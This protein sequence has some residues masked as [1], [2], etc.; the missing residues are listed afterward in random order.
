ME[1]FLV[2]G[3]VRDTLLGEP[4]KERDW[5]VVGT[6]TEELIRQGFQ[7]VGQH[8]PVFL[9]PQT[10]EEYALPRKA[11][12]GVS[13]AP[14]TVEDDLRRRDL[15]INA[16]A[17]DQHGHLIDPLNGLRDLK[18]KILR[19][20]PAFRDDPVRVL[21]LARFAARYHHLGFRI[22]PET[23]KLARKMSRTGDLSNLV[24]ER[25]FA[26][27]AK[28]MNESSPVVFIQTLQ[29]LGAL[30]E[31]IP[32]VDCLFGVP[33]PARFHPEVDTGLHTLMVLEQAC[34]LSPLPEVRF[35]ALVHDVGKGTTP[36]EDW[37]R[38]IGHESRGVPLIRLLAARLCL[39]NAWR[40]L[41]I[42]VSRYH[43]NCHRALELR[44]TTLLKTLSGLDAFR[45]P[46]RFEQFLI[47]CEADMRGREGFEEQPYPQ[48]MFWLGALQAA[49]QIDTRQLGMEGASG[50]KIRE[51]IARAR[52]KSI[53]SFKSSWLS[54]P[55]ENQIDNA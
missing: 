48:R 8:F 49:Q 30:R 2:G 24:G 9:H 12:D 7:R 10:H 37:P 1:A 40:D 55:N 29:D 46:E 31:I 38:H 4:V 43:L 51:K 3:A 17:Q 6:S 22:A 47:V 11:R 53:E 23:R 54:S 18:Q 19:H 14:V 26:E 36:R 16:M 34:L 15:T 45:N 44:A 25:V 50:E 27:I 13:E 42:A 39:P 33:Q 20:T 35:A 52:T 5:L 21:R 32:E 41:A 28:G